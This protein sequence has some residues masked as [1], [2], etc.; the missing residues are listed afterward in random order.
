MAKCPKCGNGTYNVD[1]VIFCNDLNCDWNSLRP[2]HQQRL[3]RVLAKF[4]EYNNLELQEQLCIY[5]YNKIFYIHSYK[6]S[7]KH[8]VWVI[9]DK[10]I[11]SL[12]TVESLLKDL[13]NE[14]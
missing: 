1:E 4:D 3:E 10:L 13:S 7:S 12:D 2:T 9:N 6:Y 11:I 14:S 5:H 8:L